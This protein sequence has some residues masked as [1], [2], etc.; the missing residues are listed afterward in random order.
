MTQLIQCNTIVLQKLSIAVI[1]K[2]INQCQIPQRIFYKIGRIESLCKLKIGVQ[3]LSQ[4]STTFFF[5]N[6]Q[7]KSARCDSYEE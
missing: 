2:E 7:T 3:L 6:I 5:L 4:M 1:K